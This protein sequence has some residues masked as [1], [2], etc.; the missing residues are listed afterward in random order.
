MVQRSAPVALSSNSKS[1]QAKYSGYDRPFHRRPALNGWVWR[2]KSGSITL[3]SGG[4]GERLKPAVLKTV[5]P[6]RAPGV[7]IPLPPPFCLHSGPQSSK[8]FLSRTA[9]TLNKQIDS[10]PGTAPRSPAQGTR[11]DAEADCRENRPHSGAGF[12]LRNGQAAS[13]RRYDSALR[14]GPQSLHR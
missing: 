10:M 6:E 9:N 1:L 3:C 7:R 2:V 11:M 8:P 13:Q 12:Q 4:M 14:R 5:V